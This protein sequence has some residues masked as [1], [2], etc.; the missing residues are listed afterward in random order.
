LSRSFSAISAE[1][2]TAHLRWQCSGPDGEWFAEPVATVDRVLPLRDENPV[3]HPPIITWLLVAACLA[4][5]F[6]WQPSPLSDTQ[7]DLE[8][9][10]RHAAIPCEILE[11]RPLTVDEV[12]ATF[13]FGDETA[14]EVGSS[15]SPAYD[16]G[17]DVWPSVVASM[18]L[19]G[20]LI[21][22]GGN[23]LFLWVFGNNVEDRL[24]KIGFALF[25]LA[26]GVVA[27]LAHV[28][29]GA[30]STVPVVGASG[31]IAAVMGAY[32]VWFP[33]ARVRTAVI[34]FLIALVDVRAKWLLAFWFVLQFFTS[35]DAGVAWVA[36]VAGF[37]FG[38]LVALAV[39]A[40]GGW[41]RPAPRWGTA[42]E[43]RWPYGPDDRRFGGPY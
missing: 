21:H 9:N 4:A 2:T 25:Y 23:L 15:A 29:V 33:N 7:E 17:K 12:V 35:P 22:L 5:Y 30:S 14:C 37:V 10:L 31:A 36:H 43:P 19:H 8:F 41:P 20:S 11:R 28:L 1:V 16:P 26:G 24:G 6:F 27:T 38:I 18:F 42:G 40:V 13:R 39:Q 3:R 32:L 34:F